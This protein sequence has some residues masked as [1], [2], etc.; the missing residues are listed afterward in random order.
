MKGRSNII[1][2][3]VA[4]MLPSFTVSLPEEFSDDEELEEDSELEQLR[5][6]N[7]GNQKIDR[8]GPNIHG[9]RQF[10]PT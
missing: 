7:E 4:D 5:H 10:L 1:L 3:K 9:R 8:V 6:A 2:Q